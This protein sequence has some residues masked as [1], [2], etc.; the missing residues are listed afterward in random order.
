MGDVIEFAP[1]S[2]AKATESTKA[3]KSARSE[4]DSERGEGRIV[5]FPGVRIERLAPADEATAPTT[6]T[7]ASRRTTKQRGKQR[8]K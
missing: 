2:A 1:R 5:I 6:K 7:T 4:S 3:T 8:G